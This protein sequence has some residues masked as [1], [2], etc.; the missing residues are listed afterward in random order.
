MIIFYACG[1]LGKIYRREYT[2]I[3]I[4][5]SFL[6]FRVQHCNKVPQSTTVPITKIP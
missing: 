1:K 6:H 5:R 3:R 4:S 2:Q